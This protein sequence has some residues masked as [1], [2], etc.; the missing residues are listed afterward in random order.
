M[1]KSI[2]RGPMFRAILLDLICQGSKAR[3]SDEINQ[4]ISDAETQIIR[5]LQDGEK[6]L[7]EKEVSARWPFLS[8]A[9]LRNMRARGYG[10]KFLKFGTSRNSRIFYKVMD[11]QYWIDSQYQA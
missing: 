4:L 11:I 8:L 2:P 10:P 1:K 6:L 5:F 3:S 9:M 7:C